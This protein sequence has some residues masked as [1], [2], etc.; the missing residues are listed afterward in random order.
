MSAG[1]KDAKAKEAANY[2]TRK[3]ESLTSVEQ[4]KLYQEQ[5]AIS[6]RISEKNGK[7]ELA[8]K[9]RRGKFDY[10]NLKFVE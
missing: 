8:K 1:I 6:A 3:F 5:I 4:E 7:T 10:R 9:I 2:M